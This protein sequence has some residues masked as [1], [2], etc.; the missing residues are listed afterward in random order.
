MVTAADMRR[1]VSVVAETEERSHFRT[2]DFRIGGKIFAGLSEDERVGYAKLSTELQSVL[3]S[4]RSEVFYPANS[5]WGQKGWTHFHLSRLKEA[6]CI[7]HA[8]RARRSTQVRSA[9]APRVRTSRLAFRA[10]AASVRPFFTARPRGSLACRRLKPPAAPCVPDRPA[11]ARRFATCLFEIEKS[12]PPTPDA[13]NSGIF[14]SS[15]KRMN[16]AT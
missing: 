15:K 16:P 11:L 10:L 8:I 14:V 1:L 5:A 6:E 2:P 12:E 3:M 4:A 9:I 7:D 13:R